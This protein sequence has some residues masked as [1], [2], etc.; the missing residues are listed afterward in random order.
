MHSQQSML[1]DIPLFRILNHMNTQNNNDYSKTN[2]IISLGVSSVI[3]IILLI[4]SC[5][6]WSERYNNIKR[7]LDY[8]QTN[9]LWKTGGTI[10]PNGHIINY[11]LRSFDAGRHWYAVDTKNDNFIILG[12]ANTVYPGLME[13]L[14]AWDRIVK[15]AVQNGPINLST[16]DGVKLLQSAGFEIKTNK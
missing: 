3:L 7:N 6:T 4:M 10:M 2:T 8:Y 12:E 9:Y 14:D 16:P 15:Y 13:H 5:T 1:R 11:Q